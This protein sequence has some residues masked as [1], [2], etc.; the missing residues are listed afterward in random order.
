MEEQNKCSSP[1]QAVLRTAFIIHPFLFAK[2]VQSED[3]HAVQYFLSFCRKK[4]GDLQSDLTRQH[5]VVLI[6]F[7]FFFVLVNK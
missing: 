4:T 2:A 1:V 7:F 5:L 3:L 6:C